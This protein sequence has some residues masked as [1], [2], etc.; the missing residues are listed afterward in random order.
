MDPFS[1]GAKYPRKQ[2]DGKKSCLPC[3]QRQTNHQMYMYLV[4][5]KFTG[6]S[7]LSRY[8][9]IVCVVIR[10]YVKGSLYR[11]GKP[12]TKEQLAE[13]NAVFVDGSWRLLDPFWGA[14]VM[15]PE[16][17]VISGAADWFL[18]TEPK[19]FLYSHYPERPEWQLVETPISLH[20]FEK[21]VS[22]HFLM[23]FHNIHGSSNVYAQSPI[24]ATVMLVLPEASTGDLLRTCEQ[25]RPWRDFLYM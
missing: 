6:I 4:P 18:F 5:L 3:K 24:S 16:G 20:E 12:L 23:V 7:L 1:E 14:C 15:C 17:N 10:G 9:N 2:I 25:Q 22:R 21:Q 13:W 19:Q 8:A 11:I